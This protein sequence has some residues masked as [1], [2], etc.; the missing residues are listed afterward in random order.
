MFLTSSQYKKFLLSTP[1]VRSFFHPATHTVS[2]VVADPAS[3]RAVIIDSVLDYEPASA[4]VS[5]ESADAIIEYVIDKGYSVEWILETHIHADHLSAAQYLKER[6]GGQIAIGENI[7]SVQEIFGNVFG[8]G[9][10][11]LR[12]GS[13]FDRLWKDSD[14]FTV[15]DIPAMVLHTPGHTPADVCYLIGNALFVGDT[16]FMPDYGTARVDFP[17][18]NANTLYQSVQ[19]IFALPE[20]IRIFLCHDY[21]PSG[22]T[23]FAWETSVKEEKE[24]N[25]HLNKT[26][27]IEDFVRMRSQKDATLGMPQLIIPSIQVN[28][29]A[30]ALP[31]DDASGRTFLKIPANGLFSKK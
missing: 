14:S 28:M 25:I 29:R 26:T 4:T 27:I 16:L 31:K 15:G 13:Q 19:K 22:R 11:F 2:H 30:G 17:G 6:L 5:Q 21:L 20:A 1:E 24:N 8:E 7:T 23:E 12:D 10:D 3:Q 18:G 9:P